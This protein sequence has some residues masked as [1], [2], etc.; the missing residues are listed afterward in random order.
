MSVFAVS[1]CSGIQSALEPAGPEAEAVAR[2]FGIMTIA[3]AMI[4]FAVIG[5]LVYATRERRRVHSEH[6]AGL[7][8]LWGGAIIPSLLLA[9]LLGYSFWLMPNIR[10]WSAPGEQTGLRIEV[11]GEQFWWRV[12]YHPANGP[13][14]DAANE[15]RLPVGERVEFILTSSDVIHSFWIPVLGGKMDMIPGRTNRLTLR[16]A[17]AGVYR[18]PCT[19]FCG[20]SHAL[21]AFS[22]VVMEPGDF[23]AWLAERTAASPTAGAPGHDL[24][25]AHGCP[26][27]HTIKGTEARGTVGPDLSHVGSRQTLGAGILPVSAETIASFIEQPDVVK[28]GSQMPAFRMLPEAD[29]AAIAAYLEGLR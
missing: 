15:I 19:E 3:G 1:G 12:R 7:L 9:L 16:A 20:T 21:M 29:I 2:L 17:K 27:C 10:P 6:A 25:A 24:F 22:V 23:R 5:A 11:E 14:V 13:P 28:P 26:A 4:W 18:G 8:I